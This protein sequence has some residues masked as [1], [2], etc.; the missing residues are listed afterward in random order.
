[1]KK[2]LLIVDDQE[3]MRS[4]LDMVFRDRGFDVVTAGNAADAR[5][6]AAA[7]PPDAV[8]LDVMMPGVDGWQVL[9]E[10]RRDARTEHVP[11]VVMSA[12][13][14]PRYTRQAQES[15]A[16]F[17]PKPFH[18]ATAVDTVNSLVSN[19]GDFAAA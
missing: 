10:L 15:G 8:L 3:F 2:R 6:A 16:L 14:D 17:L 7:S 4:L 13:H 11:V 5:A 18:L 12:A 19:N 9:A 1:V